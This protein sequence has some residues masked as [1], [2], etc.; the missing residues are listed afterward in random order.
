MVTQMTLTDVAG[1][2]LLVSAALALLAGLLSLVAVERVAVEKGEQR[3][4]PG[5]LEVEPVQA[6]Q[7]APDAR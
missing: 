6:F 4:E 3:P 7:I 1:L 5:W 2:V